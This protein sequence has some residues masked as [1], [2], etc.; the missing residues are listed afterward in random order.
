M[1]FSWSTGNIYY[2]FLTIE[3]KRKNFEKTI[4]DRFKVN[5]ST[6]MSEN[7]FDERKFLEQNFSTLRYQTGFGTKLLDTKIPNVKNIL[8]HSSLPVSRGK[9]VQKRFRSPR[10]E[11]VAK[12]KK[13]LKF[14]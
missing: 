7:Q 12:K 6:L 3:R 4:L 9:K 1:P 2:R 10:Y 13:F 8:G 14:L 11:N 5:D